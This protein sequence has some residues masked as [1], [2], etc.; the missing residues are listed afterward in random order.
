MDSDRLAW[1]SGSEEW[2]WRHAVSSYSEGDV[3][4]VGVADVVAA[5][6][7]RRVEGATAVLHH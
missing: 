3:A 7:T 1:Y 5:A 4:A 6:A 2:P